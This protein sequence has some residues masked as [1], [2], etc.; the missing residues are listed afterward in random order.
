MSASQSCEVDDPLSA[1]DPDPRRP[2]A[3]PVGYELQDVTIPRARSEIIPMMIAEYSHAVT[4]TA[5]FARRDITPAIGGP[6]LYGVTCFINQIWDPL[7]VTALVLDDGKERVAIAGFD[8]C[9]ILEHPYREMTAEVGKAIGVP[10][11]RVW[12]NSSHTHSSPYLSTELQQLLDPY[13][14]TAVDYGYVDQVCKALTEAMRDAAERAEPA[15]LSIGR[16]RVERVASN[17]RVKLPDGRIIHRYARAPV[18]WRRLEEGMIDPDVT[19]VRFDRSDGTAIG[20]IVNYACHPT[21]AGGDLHAWV[22]A[23]FVGVALRKVEPTLDAPCLFL[24]GCAGDIGTGKWTEGTAADDT[25]SMGDRMAAGMLAAL[26]AAEPVRSGELH[27]AQT[28]VELA[29]DPFPPLDEMEQRLKKAAE[30]GVSGEVVAAGDALV[31]ARRANEIRRPGVGALSIGDLAI[32]FLPGEV[33]LGLG[34]Q[35][36]RSSRF[37]HTLVS[38]YNNVSLQYIPTADQFAGGEFE[39]DGGWRYVAQGAGETLAT[40][41]SRLLSSL[42]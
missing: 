23:D 29:L 27:A 42:K 33:F 15:S 30:G 14:L 21:A 16:G 3:G 32:S 39:I 5:G 18:E 17:R 8:T 26:A 10:P 19:M 37:A 13:G 24:Q 28:R 34:R 41:A 7:T 25:Q 22:T 4:L 12:L 40:G 20:A 36:K 6:A 9:E 11:E 35:I 38:A 31:V 1:A 2:P